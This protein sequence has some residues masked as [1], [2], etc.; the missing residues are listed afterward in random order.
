M[1]ADGFCHHT[2]FL[3]SEGTTVTMGVA[4]LATI[5]SSNQ[6]NTVLRRQSTQSTLRLALA[7]WQDDEVQQLQPAQPSATTT[8]IHQQ[9]NS[10]KSTMSWRLPL[11]HL[12]LVLARCPVLL[13]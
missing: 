13:D 2:I 9:T 10:V 12:P 6:A 1:I 7:V 11:L 5:N 4:L 8:N 3:L